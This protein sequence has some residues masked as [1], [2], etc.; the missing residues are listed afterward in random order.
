MR[1]ALAS[2]P[3][4]PD[5]PNEDFTAAV[6][7]GAVLLDGAGTPAGSESGCRHGVAWYARALGTSLLVEIVDQDRSLADALSSAITHVRDLH[8]DTCDLNHPGTPSA[9][10]IAVRLRADRFEY[11]V[12]ADSVL[13][14]DRTNDA[15]SVITDDREARVGRELRKPM[16][17]LPTDTPEHEAARRA[18]MEA[19]RSR[20]NVTDGFW[21]ADANPE[22]AHQA[23]TGTVLRDRLNGI[24]L[25]SDGASRL[26]DRFDLASWTDTLKIL[27]HSGPHELIHRVREAERT[28]PRGERWP[29]GKTHDD[30]TAVHLHL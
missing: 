18:Y 6:P 10:V 22:A 4:G 30:A 13:L 25:L 20:R 16:D 24:S 21:V 8:A 29:R 12:L 7:G 9:T 23:L 15:P 26:A 3:A 14:L 27:E 2:E 19:L 28:D 1:V 17:A 11:L 5:R